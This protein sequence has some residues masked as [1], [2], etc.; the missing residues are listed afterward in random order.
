MLTASL[1]YS[2][3]ML[4]PRSHHGGTLKAQHDKSTTSYPLWTLDEG[5]ITRLA[6]EGG[7]VAPTGQAGGVLMF[8]GNIVVGI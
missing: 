5:D 7:I 3:L 8:H 2:P 6:D 1:P 4:I